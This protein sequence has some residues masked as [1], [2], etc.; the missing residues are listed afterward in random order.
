MECLVTCLTR[1]W[2]AWPLASHA[3]GMLGHWPHTRMGCLATGHMQMECLVTGQM[4]MERLV[5]GHHTTASL[6]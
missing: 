6:P 2:D 4:L 5:T 3:Y 1:N